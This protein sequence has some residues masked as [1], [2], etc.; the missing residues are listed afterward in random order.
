VSRNIQC[1]SAVNYCS[2]VSKNRFDPDNS[3]IGQTF[4]HVVDADGRVKI[5][6]HNT[7]RDN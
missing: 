4:G 2:D 1:Y 5:S 3:T 6:G 7:V